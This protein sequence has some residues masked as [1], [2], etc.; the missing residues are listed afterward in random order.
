[1]VSDDV[2][3]A[4]DFYSKSLLIKHFELLEVIADAFLCNLNEFLLNFLADFILLPIFQRY[5]L[6]VGIEY[7]KDLLIYVFLLRLLWPLMDVFEQSR[8]FRDALCH[9]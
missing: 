4:L 2:I 9:I 7:L 5:R 8:T 3:N 6:L 1:M